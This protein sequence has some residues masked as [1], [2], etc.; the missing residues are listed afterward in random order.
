MRSGKPLSSRPAP[1]VDTASHMIR[2]LGRGSFLVVVLMCGIWWLQLGSD[3]VYLYV[4]V[5]I[6]G[7]HGWGASSNLAAWRHLANRSLTR[8]REGGLFSC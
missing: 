2:A 8:V 6:R 1:L 7:P 3:A 5:R 4:H